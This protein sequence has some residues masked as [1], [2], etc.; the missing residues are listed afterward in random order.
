MTVNH[1]VPQQSLLMQRKHIAGRRE[2]RDGDRD[3]VSRDHA[4]LYIRNKRHS[5]ERPVNDGCVTDGPL[6]EYSSGKLQNYLQ[7]LW[8]LVA[9]VTAMC[10]IASIDIIKLQPDTP[11]GPLMLQFSN[12]NGFRIDWPML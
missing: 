7:M 3:S 12:F 2:H 10:G 9:L 1:S 4:A 8:C 5:S 6:D 11:N